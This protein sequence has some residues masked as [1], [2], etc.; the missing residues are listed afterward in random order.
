VPLA[1]DTGED[2]G[3]DT[4]SDRDTGKDTYDDRAGMDTPDTDFSVFVLLAS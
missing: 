3:I 4:G 1:L 2:T